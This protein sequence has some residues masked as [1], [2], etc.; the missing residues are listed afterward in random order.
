MVDSFIAESIGGQRFQ[1]FSQRSAI[2]TRGGI[3]ILG[4]KH[5]VEL[6]DVDARTFSLSTLV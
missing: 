3:L 2:E 5:V 4:N 6:S 1:G